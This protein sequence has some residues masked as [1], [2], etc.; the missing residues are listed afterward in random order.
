MLD[1]RLDSIGVQVKIDMSGSYV[2]HAVR[3]DECNKC[4]PSFM[5]IN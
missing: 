3:G 5:R 1:T 2:R 4:T